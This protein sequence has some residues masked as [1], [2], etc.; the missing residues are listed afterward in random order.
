M[1]RPK[2]IAFDVIETLFSLEPLRP[3]L[4]RAGLDGS[5]L[6]V[7]FASLLRDAFALGAV[8]LYRPFKE[9]A[10]STLSQMGVADADRQSI[11]EGFSS[12]SAYD[13]VRPTFERLRAQTIAVICLTNGNPDVT[14][15][16]LDREGLA[17]LVDRT[18]SID[19]IGCWKPQARVYNYAAEAAGVEPGEM[20]LVACHAW[21]CQGALSA[22]VKAGYVNRGKPYAPAMDP[23]T[24]QG[25]S[26]PEVVDMLLADQS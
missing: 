9:V 10:D 22:G 8:G 18:I 13:D 17:D 26:L 7:F 23:P 2:A 21:D 16:I 1:P 3:R 6:E 5:D 14:R 19:E 4:Q 15:T 25:S 24:A 20:A 12:L 11:F